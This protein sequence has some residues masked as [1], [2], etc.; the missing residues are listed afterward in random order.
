MTLATADHPVWREVAPHFA[1]SEFRAPD[2]MCPD[3]LRTLHRIRLRSGIPFRFVSDARLG[4]AGVAGSAHDEL[5]CRSVD[6]RVHGSRERSQ[7]VRAAYLEGLTRVGVYPPTPGQRAQWGINSGTVH[8]D[9][10][11]RLPQDVMWVDY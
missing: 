1:R 8:L 11:T 7:L 4:S 10:S 2:R 5:P 3:F 9:A 6:L